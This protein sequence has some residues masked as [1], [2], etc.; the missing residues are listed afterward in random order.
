MGLFVLDRK[1][2]E[3]VVIDHDI[4]VIVMSMRDGSVKLG[5]KADGRL[6][7]RSEVYDQRMA[8]NRAKGIYQDDKA[9]KG[10]DA[11]QGK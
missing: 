7:C 11:C 4:Q 5:F 1:I 3:G 6:V 10:G 9:A 8:S 2:G